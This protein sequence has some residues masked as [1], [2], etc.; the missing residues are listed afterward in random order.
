MTRLPTLGSW[1]VALAAC[2]LVALAVGP[3]P[4]VA[5]TWTARRLPAA[6]RA[7]FFGVSCPSTSLCVAVGG[8]NA[9]AGSSDPAGAAGA[10]S[11][12]NPGGAGPPNQNEI[13]GVSCPSS[14]LCVAVSFEGLILTS[15]NPTG[16]EA[17]WNIADLS[18]SGPNVHFYGVS[19]P[20]PT[21]CAAS[22]SGSKSLTST[23]P[24]GGAAA[25][26]ATQ[27][28]G[29]V[30]L[31]GIS[32]T[33]PA[34]CVAV[35]DDGDTTR[36]GPTDRGE[37]LAS[38]DPLGGAWQ[39]AELPGMPG[40]LYGVSC[41][42]P[43]LCV[44]GNALGNLFVSANPAGAASA[45]PVT[46][47]GG[48]V[49]VTDVDC[50][51]SSQC[52]AVDNNGD[53]LTSTDPT[54]G[55]A[56]WTFTNVAPYPGVDE[57]AANAMFGVSC[58]TATLCVV[59]A[60]EGQI[61]TSEDPFDAPPPSLKKH[62]KKPNKKRP[63][64]PRTTIA[65]SPE[66]ANELAAHKLTARFRFFARSHAQVRGFLCKLDGHPLARCRSPQAY[67][68]GFGRHLFRVRAI[69]WSGLKGPVATARF[70]VCHPTPYPN[71][72][73]HLPPLSPP[74]GR[75]PTNRPIKGASG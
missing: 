7:P 22:G 73:R 37:V 39:Q 34:F 13:K 24:T 52:V 12:V 72:L 74:S 31:R 20:A 29:P 19:C 1:A 50:L 53:V 17:A 9:I 51:S 27:L 14:R 69:G 46:D 28:P 47:G 8:G 10:W 75:V 59:V 71:C 26:S 40:N 60:Y 38:T 48:S 23:N 30:E 54:G 55:S 57:T 58:P 11:V 45:W 66:P 3:V 56:A 4:A 65:G 41:P 32:C 33:S 15:T 5:S 21:F 42:S 36:P 61:F 63:R 18:P 68:V 44:S 35:G 25:W 43:A 16:G 62:V 2:W 64:R 49:Q 67:R 6:G 70:R